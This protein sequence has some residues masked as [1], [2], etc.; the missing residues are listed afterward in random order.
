MARNVIRP[1]DSYATAYAKAERAYQGIMRW[2]KP[3][4]PLPSGAQQA[5]DL[6]QRYAAL[7]GCR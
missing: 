1:T 3:G 2:W 7:L 4:E 6:M 5:A